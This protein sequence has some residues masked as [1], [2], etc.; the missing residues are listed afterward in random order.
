MRVPIEQ[1]KQTTLQ[2][3]L[4]S[5]YDA[6]E[7]DIILDVL[8]YAQLRGNN[9]GIIKLTGAGMPKSADAGQ[10]RI[11]HETKLSARLDGAQNQGMVVLT[12]ATDMA[13]EK[14]HAHDIGMVGTRNTCSSTG[15]IGY[16]ASRIAREGFIGLIFAG[17]R[18]AVAMYG[19]YEPLF[20]TNPLAIGIPSAAKPIVFDMAT[21]AMA[22][23]GILEAKIAGKMLPQGVAYDPE[24]QLTTD[25]AA[26]LAGAIRPFGG[27]K[28][29]ALSLIVEVLT[30]PLVGSAFAGLGDYQ[31]DWGNLVLAIN[32]ELLID[33]KTFR[34][35][36]AQL[37]ER[38]KA[39]KP[40]PGVEEILIPGERGDRLL[41]AVQQ[42]GVVEIEDN[43]WTELQK[44]AARA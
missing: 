35:N 39:A 2:A 20:G 17:S 7:A 28:G 5:G 29:A 30:G 32:P 40:L 12:R 19:S 13:L 15:A 18:P 21:S 8:M 34:H 38:V 26:A 25:P 1:L 27:Y 10:I 31:H 16:Y 23:F 4:N 24:G 36:V 3:I 43:L 33:R 44:A 22:W 9:Q 37:T 14:A 6:S 11:E 41:E 42:A